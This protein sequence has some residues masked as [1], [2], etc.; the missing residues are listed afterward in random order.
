MA[1]W[2]PIVAGVDGS[3]HAAGAAALAALSQ[4]GRERVARV[5]RALGPAL[6]ARPG[7]GCPPRTPAPAGA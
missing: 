6:A 1:T 5:V 7:R 3:P 2:K 4:D